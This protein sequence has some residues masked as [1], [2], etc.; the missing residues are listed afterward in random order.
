MIGGHETHGVLNLVTIWVSRFCNSR[1]VHDLTSL[2]SQC[3]NSFVKL[4]MRVDVAQMVIVPLTTALVNWKNAG[5][6]RRHL[7]LP[8][9]SA[10]FVYGMIMLS[11]ALV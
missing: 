7:Y 10:A 2:L 11:Q 3:L 1:L 6:I 4:L 9:A 5:R 8:L